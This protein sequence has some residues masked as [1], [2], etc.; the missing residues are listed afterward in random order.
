MRSKWVCLYYSGLKSQQIQQLKTIKRYYF[1]HP[2]IKSLG[3][4]SLSW[5]LHLVSQIEVKGSPGLCSFLEALK[6]NLLLN[7][8]RLLRVQFHEVVGSPI[9]LLIVSHE[10]FPALQVCWGYWSCFP[11][12]LQPSK[13]TSSVS[14]ALNLLISPSPMSLLDPAREILCF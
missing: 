7:S 11:F 12:H 8:F 13:N 6:L 10:S 14:H 3:I 5:V 2:H 9:S 1:T 4:A